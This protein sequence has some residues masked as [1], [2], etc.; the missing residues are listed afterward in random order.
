MTE[1]LRISEKI[2]MTT[3]EKY[4]IDFLVNNSGK[5]Y[6]I[7]IRNAVGENFDDENDFDQ[8]IAGLKSKN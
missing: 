1:R 2:I 6:Y 8:T 4:I 7:D 3:K 5:E